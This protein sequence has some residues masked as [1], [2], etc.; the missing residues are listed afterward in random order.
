M[1]SPE[2]LFQA[3]KVNG[4]RRFAGV[5]DSLL[6]ELCAFITDNVPEDAHVITANEGNAIALAS[7]WYLG[8]GEPALVYMQNSG[9]GNAVNPLAS[10][11]DPE[12]YGIP[13]LLVIGWRGEP[14]RKDEPQHV[15]QGR[16]TLALLDSLEIPYRTLGPEDDVTETVNSICSEMRE[17]GGPAAIVVREG[18]FSA[19]KLRKKKG[20]D[21]QMDREAAIVTV[22]GCLLPTD[23]VVS[24]TGKASRELYECRA[25]SGKCSESDFLTVGSMGHASS[26]ALGLAA[27]RPER[28][29]LCFDGDGAFIMHMGALAIIGRQAPPNL[30]HLV[31]NNGSHDSVGGQPTVG[32]EIDMVGIAKACGYRLALSVSTAEE[33]ESAMRSLPKGDG[34]VFLEV[35]V[36]GGARPDLGRPKTSP[37]ENRDQLMANLRKV[38]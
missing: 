26:I 7:G 15:K 21:F 1:I 3:L 36:N 16:V 20:T 9:I 29:V 22:V 35:K 5:P 31:F 14:G 10:L 30:V 24:T 37:K 6:K 23:V 32:L 13:M 25:R 4:I 18:T 28:R 38:V 12:V 8:T 2:D 19:Y 11:S 33:L 34:P 17:R 27:T